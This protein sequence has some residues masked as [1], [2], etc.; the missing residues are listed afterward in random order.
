MGGGTA[1]RR[2]FAVGFAARVGTRPTRPVAHGVKIPNEHNERITPAQVAA[3]SGSRTHARGRRWQTTPARGGS[4]SVHARAHHTAWALGLL[5]SVGE[6][7]ASHE[8][9][10]IHPVL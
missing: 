1:Q 9:R 8:D 2:S 5:R 4:A 10:M 6:T 7:T 3:E